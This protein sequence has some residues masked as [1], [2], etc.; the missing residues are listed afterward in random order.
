MTPSTDGRAS[1]SLITGLYELSIL[2]QLLHNKTTVDQ[3]LHLLFVDLEKVNDSVFLKKLWKAL[4]HYNINNSIITA[5][6]RLYENSISK[7][8][9]GKQHTSEFYVTK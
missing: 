8:K 7:I 1:L 2:E 3:P 4:E 5:I 6:K 9:I